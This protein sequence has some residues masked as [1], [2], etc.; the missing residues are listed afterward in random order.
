MRHNTTTYEQMPIDWIKGERRRIR[1]M[2][3]QRSVQL[4]E[5]YRKGNTISPDCPLMA[6]LKLQHLNV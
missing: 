4:L 1:N 5:S 3:A 6:S 2:L